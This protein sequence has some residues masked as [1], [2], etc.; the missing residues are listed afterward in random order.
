MTEPVARAHIVMLVSNDATTD[1]RVRKTALAAAA[2]GAR[3]TLVALAP[4]GVRRDTSL[5]DVRITRVPVEFTLRDAARARAARRR[6]AGLPLLRPVTGERDVVLRR[7]LAARQRDSADGATLRRTTELRRQ[8]MRARRFAG[9][10]GAKGSRL[11][12]GGMD[13]LRSRVTLAAAWR[14]VLPEVDDYEIAFGP[15][16]DALRPDLI[17]AHDVQLL[18]VAARAVRRAAA[19]GRS[20][21]WVYDAHEW[22]PGLSRYG[23]RTARKV[24]AWADL[25]AE[26]IRSANAVITV[27]DELADALQQRHR[28][29]ERP[30]VVHNIPSIAHEP[31]DRVRSGGIRAATGVPEG[32]PLLVYSGGVTRARGVHTAVEARLDLPD[33]HLAVVAVPGSDSPAARDIAS[34][35]EGLGLSDRVHVID[36]VPPAEVVTFLR[37]ADVGLIPL[38]HFGSHE[39][40][41][42]NKLFEYLHAGLPMVVSDCRAQAQ[43]VTAHDLGAVHVADEPHSLSAAVRDV[44]RRADDVR[45]AVANAPVREEMTW[46]V[47]VL[48]LQALLARL[49]AGATQLPPLDP[50]A[51]VESAPEGPWRAQRRQLLVGMGPTNSAGQAWAWMSALRRARPDVQTEVIAIRNDV[52]DYPADVQV[53]KGVFAKDATWALDLREH[54]RESWTH[55]VV[56]AGRGLFGTLGGTDAR[57][58]V[59]Y[60]QNAG[61]QVALAF[62][63]SEI[64]DPAAHAAA[65]RASPFANPRDPYTARLQQV[66]DRNLALAREFEGP[67]FVSTPDQL[68][69]LPRATWLPVVVDLEVWP[70]QARETPDVPLVVHAPSNPVLKGTA[71]IE[72]ALQPLIDSGRI[73]Y[74]RVTGMQPADAAALVRRADIVIDQVLLGLYGVLACEGLAS[75]AVVLGHLG[76]RLRSRV[77]E[78]VPVTEVTV[79]DLG[80]RLVEVLDDLP[81]LAARAPERRS[82]V[83]RWHDGRYAASVLNVFVGEGD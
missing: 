2:T 64:R 83:E 44:L 76:D 82:F 43:F 55:A 36:P 20:V 5:G 37:S 51:G 24:A 47:Q 14:R 42:S 29:P 23:S 67:I 3:V 49:T 81:N 57:A 4:D 72:A 17:Y 61:I 18:P 56:E 27:S 71:Q 63:G 75:G 11:V 19:A 6:A 16:V 32:T 1:A 12:W 34:L 41:L 79:E 59:E 40:A 62:H 39:F 69:Y 74:A 45:A 54:A 58:D 50:R 65:H 73:R 38:R 30:T 31:A 48:H 53:A 26:Y 80:D 25:E 60:L 7:Q 33:T 46:P 15:V 78:E 9:R 77:P 28:L 70:L 21:P 68:D 52:Y 66:A 10:L 8:S 22:V 13:R 35:A